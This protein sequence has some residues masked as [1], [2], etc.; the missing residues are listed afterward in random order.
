M[1]KLGKMA[2]VAVLA[3]FASTA[4]AEDG[5]WNTKYGLLFGLQNVFQNSGTLQ[6]YDGGT[7]IGVGVQM[8]LAPTRAIRAFANLSRASNP[9]YEVTTNGQVSKQLPL[10]TSHYDEVVGAAY[11]VRMT[12]GA[13]APYIGAGASL[14]FEQ[15][16][17]NGDAGTPPALT[18]YDNKT[19]TFDVGLAGTLGVEWR[20]HKAIAI[21]AEY[22]LDMTLIGMEKQDNKVTTGTT[23]STSEYSRTRFL[24]FGTGVGQG[25]QL[26]IVAFF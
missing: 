26:G 18:S 17:R 19:R 15:S 14:R 24:N 10:E 13:I 4:M 8:N 16:S 22:G 1:T 3:A 20:V 25:G 23:V 5:G 11:M 7:G 21:F 2:V 9:G 6:S 12:T